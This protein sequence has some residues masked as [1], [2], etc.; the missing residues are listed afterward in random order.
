LNAIQSMASNVKAKGE[1][2]RG[3]KEDLKKDILR[4]KAQLS[5][6]EDSLPRPSGRYLR[7]ILG[8]INVS[9]L[10]KDEKY[11]YKGKYERFKLIVNVF[12]VL[13]I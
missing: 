3:E 8:D 4:R 1:V 13:F 12:G 7:I 2:E 6:M 11:K 9:I 5:Q 10:D